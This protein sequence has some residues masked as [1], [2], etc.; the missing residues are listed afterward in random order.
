MP[1]YEY[2]CRSCGATTEMIQKVSDA[3]LSDCPAC[4]AAGLI[5]LVSASGF[6]LGGGG[7]YETDF[8][9]EGK[10]NLKETAKSEAPASGTSTSTST[11][12][13]TTPASAS[14]GGATAAK[15]S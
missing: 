8:K 14:G 12:T 1:I 11:G 4:G 2:E 10:R 6:R 5:K 13:S 15:V 7:W 3:P 9:K